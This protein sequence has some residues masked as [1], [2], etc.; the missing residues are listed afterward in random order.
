MESQ[1]LTH[2]TPWGMGWIINRMYGFIQYWKKLCE[3]DITIMFG[4]PMKYWLPIGITFSWPCW[5]LVT[6]VN[7]R[8]LLKQ[9]LWPQSWVTLVEFDIMFFSNRDICEEFVADE[10]YACLACSRPSPLFREVLDCYNLCMCK[11]RGAPQTNLV[12][13]CI[14]VTQFFFQLALSF[15][16]LRWNF[17]VQ[18]TKFWAFSTPIWVETPKKVSSR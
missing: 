14:V 7:T 18:A 2:L 17:A 9:G 11:R 10:H 3:E 12:G 1:H 15:V 4:I 8:S 13:E 16:K 6:C 5:H